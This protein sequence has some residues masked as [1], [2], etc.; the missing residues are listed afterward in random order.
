MP[1]LLAYFRAEKL[2][3]LVFLLLGLGAVGAS[4]FLLLRQ[5]PWRALALPFLLIGLIQV[6]VGGT[7]YART[8]RQVATLQAELQRAPEAARST[9]VARM[10]AVMRSFQVYKAIEIAV[11]LLGLGLILAT[12]RGSHLGIAGWGF[13]I[14]AVLMLGA[15]H[16]AEARGRVYLQ[17]LRSL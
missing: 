11:F 17:W 10:E 12:R 5:H 6:V 3:S 1:N 7:V 9:E 2:E 8:E 4:A 15:D 13:V 16:F 14:Q